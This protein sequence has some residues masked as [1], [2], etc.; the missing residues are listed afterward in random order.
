M[1]AAD[2]KLHIAQTTLA[3]LRSASCQ[4]GRTPHPVFHTCLLEGT[5]K[6]VAHAVVG[7]KERPGCLRSPKKGR[8]IENCCIVVSKLDHETFLSRANIT[9]IGELGAI[10]CERGELTRR[11]LPAKQPSGQGYCSI[12]TQS[13]SLRPFAPVKLYCTEP[14]VVV[15][16]S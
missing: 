4:N 12:V 14:A 10:V 13:Q 11:N 8:G 6:I 1:S 5:T 7:Q 16:C 2:G 15:V 9:R 3:T